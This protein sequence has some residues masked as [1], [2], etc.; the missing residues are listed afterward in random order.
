MDKFIVVMWPE[1]QI[2]MDMPNFEHNSLL[3]NDGSLY[4]KYG[5]SAYMVNE[6][7]L[8]LYNESQLNALEN[9]SPEQ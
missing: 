7:W 6:A 4:E 1:S 3:I 5:D 8:D 2:L 9:Q